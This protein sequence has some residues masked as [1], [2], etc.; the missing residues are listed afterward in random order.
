M[1]LFKWLATAAFV[2]ALSATGLAQTDQAKII[3]SVR[4][5]TGALIPDVMVTVRN[6]RTSET[7]TTTTGARGL[8]TITPLRPSQY[9]V[10]LEKSGFATLEYTNMELAL[11]QTLALDFEVRPA[12]VE[13]QVTVTAE[14]PIL[15]LSSAKVGVNVTEREVASLPRGFFAFCCSE[16]RVEIRLSSPLLVGGARGRRDPEQP[17]DGSAPPVPPEQ[18]VR[19]L[20]GHGEGLAGNRRGGER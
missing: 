5:Q 7:R 9:T 6:E 8:F 18:D 11:G 20:V 3:G 14:A 1:K 16:D 17:G 12:G 4:D 13:E 10:R 15:E 2:A 19:D